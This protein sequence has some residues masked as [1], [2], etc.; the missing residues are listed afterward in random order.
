MKVLIGAVMIS[1]MM[2]SGC[3]KVETL[4]PVIEEQPTSDFCEALKSNNAWLDGAVAAESRWGMPIYVSLAEL[5][6]KIGTESS[7]YVAPVEGDWEQYRIA[8][9][10][11]D[12]DP[13]DVESALDFIGWHGR[14]AVER[15][16]LRMEQAG[17]LYLASRL[18]HG[19]LLRLQEI[20][21]AV[22]IRQSEQVDQLA[23]QYRDQL[24]F[25][26]RIRERAGSFFRWPW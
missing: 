7:R 18:G 20:S 21:D 3:T 5:N 19:G 16:Q 25:C 13:S 8:T 24:K 2:L 6:L 23:A 17:Q 22:L 26:P 14:L 4:L 15:N 12:A 11:W 10:A 9:E 1:L